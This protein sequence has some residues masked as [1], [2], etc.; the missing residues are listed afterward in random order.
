MCH[1]GRGEWC[2]PGP[3]RV[4][5]RALK[6]VR[7]M[8]ESGTKSKMRQDGG[9]TVG[10]CPVNHDLVPCPRRG[11]IRASRSGCARGGMQRIGCACAPADRFRRH[12]EPRRRMKKKGASGTHPKPP[13]DESPLHIE[14]TW[15]THPCLSSH[16]LFNQ[17][18]LVSEMTPS[19]NA[20]KS[21]T[22]VRLLRYLE[23][24]SSGRLVVRISKFRLCSFLPS[25]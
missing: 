5:W 22:S 11:D 17:S 7:S 2:Q 10:P 9:T 24:F 6:S 25:K 18:F 8:A 23:N 12:R 1:Q 3:V 20:T 16:G 4:N 19:K 21:T 13:E 14:T 15:A